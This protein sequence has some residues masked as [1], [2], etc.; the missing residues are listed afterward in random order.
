[1]YTVIRTSKI[2]LWCE[3]TLNTFSIHA[4]IL[5]FHLCLMMHYIG[6]IWV[7]HNEVKHLYNWLY[8]SLSGHFTRNTAVELGK[9]PICLQRSLNSLRHRF[10]KVLETFL[11]DFGPCWLNSI[12]QLLQIF[13]P[14]IHAVN[15]SFHLI[16][17]VFYWIEI[18]GLCRPLE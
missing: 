13:Q 10:S 5:S 12:M 14:H 11:R 7:Y 3:D 18:R 1:M 8:I 2:H 17:K 15:L 4:N 9:T 16:L 6:Y